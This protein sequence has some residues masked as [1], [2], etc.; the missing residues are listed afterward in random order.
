MEVAIEAGAEDLTDDGD[1]LR[2]SPARPDDLAA[3]ARRARGGGHDRRVGRAVHGAVHDGAGRPT[4][5]RPKR[6]LRLLEALDDHDDVQ[7][8]FA[9]FDIPDEVLA[10]FDG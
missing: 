8:V 1:Q 10:G 3:R 4:K 2:R 5:A 9:N 7:N 6:V